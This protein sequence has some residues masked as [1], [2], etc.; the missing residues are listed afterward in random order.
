MMGRRLEITEQEN[1]KGKLRLLFKKKIFDIH[2]HYRHHHNRS[3]DK[4]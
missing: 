2:H 3:N 4:Q 1:E